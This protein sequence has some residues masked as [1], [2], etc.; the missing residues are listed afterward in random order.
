VELDLA[1]TGFLL[2]DPRVED[3]PIVYVN[4][5]FLEMTG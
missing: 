5:P 1:G 3:H 2:T 4:E